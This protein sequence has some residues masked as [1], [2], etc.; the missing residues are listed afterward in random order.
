VTYA[1]PG[2]GAFL[3]GATHAPVM[4]I[5][6]VF[7]MTLDADL[8]FPLIVASISAR[9]LSATI[10]PKTVYADALGQ[11]SPAYPWSLRVAALRLPAGRSVTTNASMASVCR[12]FSCHS[13][14]HL[15]VVDAAGVYRRA[16]ALQAARLVPG[17]VEGLQPGPV[18]R[19]R[20]P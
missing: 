8:Q 2:T 5:L 13:M 18:G 6:M 14:Q 12:Q 17:K 7:E 19:T 16:V 3:A 10:R 1:G 4:A 9:Y 15:W 11:E 20:S